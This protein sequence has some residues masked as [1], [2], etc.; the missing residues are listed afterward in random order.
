M[1][2]NVA[3]KIEWKT[4]GGNIY[5]YVLSLFLNEYIYILIN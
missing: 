5:K 4:R 1:K 3:K 2:Q